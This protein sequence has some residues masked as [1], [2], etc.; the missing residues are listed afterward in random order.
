MVMQ[1]LLDEFSEIGSTKCAGLPAHQYSITELS[2]RLGVSFKLVDQFEHGFINPSGEEK[3]Y[4]YLL[5]KIVAKI[6]S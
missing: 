5:Y 3:H 1:F 6:K 2:Q 4:I